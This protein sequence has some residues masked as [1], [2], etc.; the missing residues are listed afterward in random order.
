[1]KNLLVLVVAILTFAFS[2]SSFAVEPQVEPEEENK[3]VE[4]VIV[5]EDQAD[6]VT[7]PVNK[8]IKK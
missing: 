4:A 8:E 2:L 6:Q 1:M 3:N 7:P 5:P